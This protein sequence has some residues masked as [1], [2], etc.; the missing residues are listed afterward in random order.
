MIVASHGKEYHL[1]LQRSH[2][3]SAAKLLG[4]WRSTDLALEWEEL[5]N[6]TAQ[7]DH[8]WVET[9]DNQL[10]K[11]GAPLHFLQATLQ[12]AISIAERSM[13]RS[14][15]QST[16]GGVLVSRHFE[17]LY[18][19][20]DEPAAKEAVKNWQ[21]RRELWMQSLGLNESWV[22]SHYE[23]LL[24]ADTLSL[25]ILC[26][27]SDFTHSLTLKAKDHFFEVT[28]SSRT[29]IG[30]APWPFQLPSLEFEIEYFKVPLR[31]YRSSKDLAAQFRLES[32]VVEQV[33]VQP[34]KA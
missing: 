13:L 1:F 17:Y 15:F 16:K 3:L 32:R 5:W 4:L 26:D 23:M 7:H 12:D 31:N 19:H 25:K 2:A 33:K 21:H 34:A 27:P 29:D 11:D 20:E 30:L 22:D 8:G 9:E 24:W 18:S 28:R 10:V 14:Y 6:A